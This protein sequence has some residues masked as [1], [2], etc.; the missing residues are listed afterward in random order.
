MKANCL[1]RNAI[2]TIDDGPAGTI[3]EAGEGADATRFGGGV[4]ETAKG[5]NLFCVVIDG[6]GL[7][8]KGPITGEATETTHRTE[9][10]GVVKAYGAVPGGVGNH[11]VV[12]TGFVRTKWGNEHGYPPSKNTLTTGET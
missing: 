10:F 1:S 5:E 11:D 2:D 3:K 4:L 9:G 6:E 12:G 8:R 7:D